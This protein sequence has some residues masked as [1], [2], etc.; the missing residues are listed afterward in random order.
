[1][2]TS[3]VYFEQLS[4]LFTE[5]SPEQRIRIARFALSQREIRRAL[6]IF[7]MMRNEEKLEVLDLLIPMVYTNSPYEKQVSELILELPHEQ[8]I[9]IAERVIFSSISEWTD[10]A[11]FDGWLYLLSN[12]SVELTQRLAKLAIEHKDP[13]IQELGQEHLDQLKASGNLSRE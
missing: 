4:A 9:P 6:D 2:A 12:I 8:L 13:S 10:R 11:D 5:L 1:M 3:S 7:N